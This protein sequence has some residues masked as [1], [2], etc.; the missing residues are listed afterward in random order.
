MAEQGFQERTEK[1][2]SRRKEKA[3]EEGQ[4]A[5]SMEVNSG[6]MLVLGLTTLY[7]AGP[8]LIENI[9][10]NMKHLLGNIANIAAADPT[11]VTLF[12]DS[13]V[14]FFYALAPIFAILVIVALGAN[15]SQVGFMVTT[16]PLEPKLDKLDLSKGVKR[17]ISVRSLVTLA[18]DSF[19]LIVVSVVGYFAIKAEFDIFMLMPDMSVSALAAEMAKSSLTVGLKVAAVLAL[20]AIVDYLYQRHDWEK[21][22]RMSKQELKEEFKDTEGSPQI[23]QKTR[24]IQRDMARRRMMKAVP[25]ADV[26]VTNPTHLAVALKYDHDDTIH[27]APYVVAKGER[28][29]AQRIK[30]VAIE[31]GI[32]VVEDKPLARALYKMCDVGQVIPGNLYRAVAELLAYVYRLKGKVMS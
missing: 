17:L 12:R 21:N 15:I 8:M 32:P 1:A 19:K 27:P 10:V 7:F 18:R 31:H 22:L 4:V 20:I 28:L 6:I 3:R 29:I 9:S 11:Y 13:I 16:K 2:T 14:N 24:Q 26:V 30:Q 5:K 23:K 25:L